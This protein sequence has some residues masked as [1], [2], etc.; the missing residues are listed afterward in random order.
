[1]GFSSNTISPVAAVATARHHLAKP[2]SPPADSSLTLENIIAT[3]SDSK[4]TF[5]GIEHLERILAE[6][7]V[8]LLAFVQVT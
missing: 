1:M 6:E 3:I 4:L 8:S 2:P 7:K 5:D